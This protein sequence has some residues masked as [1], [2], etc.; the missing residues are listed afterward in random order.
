MYV[1]L[2][3]WIMSHDYCDILVRLWTP[4]LHCEASKWWK[5][6][7]HCLIFRWN[8][9]NIRKDCSMFCDIPNDHK[10]EWKK[11]LMRCSFTVHKSFYHD[12]SI[13]WPDLV[14]NHNL[15]CLPFGWLQNLVSW[16]I[17]ADLGD[18]V[19]ALLNL[20]GELLLSNQKSYE[21]KIEIKNWK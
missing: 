19:F 17:V 1:Q 13:T 11:S 7:C 2:R 15:N 5:S 9:H 12:N 16:N 14:C 20:I 4:D 3:T 10:N 6:S 21:T 18:W 8:F